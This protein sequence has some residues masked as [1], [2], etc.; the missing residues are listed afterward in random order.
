MLW[1]FKGRMQ[2]AS[3][4]TPVSS[5]PVDMSQ[6]LFCVEIYRENAG[7]SGY[8]EEHRGLTLTV[9]T[10]SVRPHCLGRKNVEEQTRIIKSPG[11]NDPEMV[12]CRFMAS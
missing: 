3:K 5:E 4:A 2:E 12:V 6:E 7:R 11:P 8:L 9:R 1:K 10:P